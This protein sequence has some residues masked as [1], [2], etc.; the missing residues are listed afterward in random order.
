MNIEKALPVQGFMD[1]PELEYIACAANKSVNIVEIGSWR[2]RSAIGMAQNT[3]GIVTCVD[4][5]S[6]HLEASDHFDP[7]CFKDFLRNTKG[8]D[9]ILPVPL[10]SSKAAKVFANAGHLFDM[11]FID[12]RHDFEGVKADIENWTPLLSP[13]GILCGHDYGHSDWPDVVSVV[14]LIIPKFRVVPNTTIWTTEG[15]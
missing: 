10:E 11:I 12:G 13:G 6:G 8:F 2:G 3:D 5:W 7:E 9:N 1:I 4:T 14:N 15:V